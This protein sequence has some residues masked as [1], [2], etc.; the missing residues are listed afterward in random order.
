[1]AT[2]HTANRLDALAAYVVP[3]FRL[4]VEYFAA[5]NWNTVTSVTSDRTDGYSAFGSFNFTP[6]VSAFGRYDYVKPSKDIKPALKDGYWNIGLNWEPVKIVDLAL[7]YKH[8]NVENGTLST[9]NGTIGGSNKGTY[10]ELGLF[11]QF[12]W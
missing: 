2:P 6:Q 10:D 5:S 11:G 9:S 7:V 1:V 8:D 12:R 3:K 4:G